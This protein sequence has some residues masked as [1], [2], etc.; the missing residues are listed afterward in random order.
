MGLTYDDFCRLDYGE[1][2][3]VHRAYM[4]KYDAE[5]KDRWQRMRLLATI[6]IQPH[7]DRRHKITPERLLPFPW[8]KKE[9]RGMRST[10]GS[11]LTPEERRRRMESLVERLGDKLI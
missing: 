3:A 7:L 2:S 10:P 8:E 1:F 9:K 5:Y 11:K 4:E 6:T